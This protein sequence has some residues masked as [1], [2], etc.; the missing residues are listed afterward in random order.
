MTIVPSANL[1]NSLDGLDDMTKERVCR[2]TC[3]FVAKHSSPKAAAAPLPILSY[4]LKILLSPTSKVLLPPFNDETLR[5]CIEEGV[6]RVLWGP[7]V[8]PGAA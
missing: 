6:V 5:R 7:K 4:Q 1:Q 2:D 8:C 3:A